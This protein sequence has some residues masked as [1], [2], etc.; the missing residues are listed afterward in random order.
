MLLALINIGSSAAFN[1]FTSV[2]VSAFYVSFMISAITLLVRKL[3]G[4]QLRYG[5]F[6][7]GRFGIPVTIFALSYSLIGAFFSL[8]PQTVA[9]TLKEM[10]WAV[11]IF[12]G[13]IFF[14]LLYWVVGA[15]KTYTG[16]VVEVAREDFP[17]DEDPHKPES[18]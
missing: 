13:I 10:N 9:P 1:A 8:W 5:P 16:P 15:R 6:R 4:E 12:A 7:L 3:K 14:S 18:G 11:V 2:A 17:L